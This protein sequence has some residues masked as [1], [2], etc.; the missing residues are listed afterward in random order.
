[1]ISCG[2]SQS[3]SLEL[4]LDQL[5]ERASRVFCESNEV[6]YIVEDRRDPAYVYAAVHTLWF[7]PHLH[8]SRDGGNTWGPAVVEPSVRCV[9]ETSL[10][11]IWYIQ[12]GHEERPGVVWA[13]GPRSIPGAEAQGRSFRRVGDG[14]HPQHGPCLVICR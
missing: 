8:V 5:M 11:R 7:G 6:N 12:P 10:D 14:F 9:A 13:G 1:M 4:P 3:V 2:R